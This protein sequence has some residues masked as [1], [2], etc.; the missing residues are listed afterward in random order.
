MFIPLYY[1]VSLACPFT[2]TLTFTFTFV[3][4]PYAY[5]H[6]HTHT[7][8]HTRTH[9]HTH[10]H[11]LTHTQHVHIHFALTHSLVVETRKSFATPRHQS[12]SHRILNSTGRWQNSR[13]WQM[14]R[15]MRSYK[16][17]WWVVIFLVTFPIT[18]WWDNILLVSMIEQ[19]SWPH[20]EH[21][22]E[23]YFQHYV[24]ICAIISNVEV[25]QQC[26]WSKSAS[27]SKSLKVFLSTFFL[28]WIWH[29]LGGNFLLI[30][31]C[32]III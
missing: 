1:T 23:W 6:T 2:C 9:T 32:S 24:H 25:K 14:H 21:Q 5:T 15:S 16:L 28:S 29:W 27:F 7:H 31:T 18:S 19:F 8:V 12:R 13:E 11:S 17:C 30:R 20:S 26:L 4:T 10:S 3:H 22:T